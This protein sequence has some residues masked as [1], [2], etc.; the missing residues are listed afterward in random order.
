MGKYDGKKL[1]M[2][3][4]N[5]LSD[6]MCSYAKLHGA[7]VVAAD[8]NPI[9]KSPAKRIADEALDISTADIDAL[10]EY[11][12]HNQ[13][14]GVLAGVSEFNLKSARAVAERCGLPFY[15]NEAQWNSIE[16][17]DEFRQ[18]CIEY[19]VPCP[20]TYYS[21]DADGL[22]WDSIEYPVVLKPIDASASAGVHFCADRPDVEKWLGDAVGHS[23]AGKIILEQF[24][25]GDEFTAHYVI[26]GGRAELTCI[27]NRYPVTVH[28]G[29]VTTVPIARLYPCLYLD[30][31]LAQ[32]DGQMRALCESLGVKDGVLFV[33]G[34]YDSSANEFAIFEAGLRSAGEAP[35]RF[36][37]RVT[38]N[39]YMNI[40]VDVALGVEPS[41]DF[42]RN[43]P[44]LHGRCCGVI[45]FVGRGGE[46]CSVTGL[47][48]DL[49]GL[50]DVVA[51][52]SRYPAGSTIPD[53]DTLRQLAIRFILDC[54]SREAMSDTVSRLNESVDVLD[55]NGESLVIKMDPKRVFEAR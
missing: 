51:Y 14:D 20:K 38:G 27:D 11:V 12:E 9:E 36:L 34:L 2:L 31:Y 49:E 4:S 24:F 48:G 19:G 29:D 40:F 3:G 1:L 8:W 46:V 52:E 25:T 37:K 41:F 47:P 33:Q 6:D 45:S 13:V 54:P 23:S 7:Y 39:D 17:K 21:G 44:Y 35:C 15:C 18:L 16:R 30:E 32:V 53:G 28:D 42:S 55:A 50:D 22:D 26:C 10:C 43:D 5:V